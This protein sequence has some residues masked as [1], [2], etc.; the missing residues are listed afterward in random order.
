MKQFLALYATLLL[1]GILA[2][3]LVSLLP[4]AASAVGRQTL[5]EL[6]GLCF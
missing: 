1:A 2:M 4:G 5:A 3:L 6:I